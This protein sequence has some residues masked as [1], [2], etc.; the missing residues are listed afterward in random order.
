MGSRDAGWLEAPFGVSRQIIPCVLIDPL[1]DEAEEKSQ[2][3]R[4]AMGGMGKLGVARLRQVFEG[5]SDRTTRR[6]Q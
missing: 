4:R 6:G 1:Q 3:V 5:S 2:R